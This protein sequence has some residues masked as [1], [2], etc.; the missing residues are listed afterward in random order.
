MVI[1]NYIMDIHGS[2]IDM[3]NCIMDKYGS[4]SIN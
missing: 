2:I 3:Q 4:G 1:H